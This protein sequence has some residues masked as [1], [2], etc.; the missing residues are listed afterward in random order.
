MSLHSLNPLL[1]LAGVLLASVAAARGEGV[2]PPLKAVP[3]QHV[4]IDDPFWS[5]KLAVWRGVTISDCLDKFDH[6]GAMANFDH[7]ARGE[8]NAAH[9]GPSFY[10]GLSYELIRAAADFLAERPDA[11]MEARVDGEIARIAAAAARDPDGYINTYTEM[12]EPTHRWGQNGGNDWLQHDV[13]N[14]GCLVDAAVHYYRAT[15]KTALLAVAVRLA[16]S[17]CHLMGP[18][19]RQNII[20]G[21]AMAEEAMVGLYQLFKEQPVLRKNLS[22]PVDEDQYLELARFWIDMRGHHEGRVDFGAFAQDAIPVLQETAIEGHAVRAT[23]MC[24]GMSAIGMASGRAE[25]ANAASRLWASMVGRRMYLTGGVGSFADHEEFGPDYV[26]P[27]NGYAETCAAVGNGFFDYNMNLAT[28]DAAAADELE[29]TLY[30]GSLAG[31]SLAG[32]TYFY[33]NPLEAG[34]NRLRWPW[35]F[36]PCCPPMFLKLMAAL[37]GYVYAT[38]DAGGV[39]LNLFI[40]SRATM[41]M[42]RT[43]LTLSQ[44]T[45]YPWA[46]DVRLNVDPARPTTFDLHIRIPAWSRGGPSAGGLYTSTPV[47]AAGA[48]TLLIN[49]QPAADVKVVRGYAQLHREWRGGDVVTLH[50]DM[51]VERVTA[52]PHV[53]ADRGRTALMRGPIVYCLESIDNAGR[54]RDLFLPD[55]ASV[56]T[57]DRREMLGGVVVLHADGRR[58]GKAGALTF[59]LQ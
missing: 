23:L 41:N 17:M 26:L 15:G 5:P 45:Q 19:P 29:R 44:T 54:V 36:C 46:G 6:E 7:V 10:D 11:A 31:V 40:G 56:S 32:N 14:A 48:F 43:P 30:N 57:E 1:G 13:Y 9:G 38:D 39:Y 55:S 20:P 16:N 4:S 25:Y 42:A 51:P 53:E 12:K 28:G 37:P 21:H 49:G 22:L 59:R 2:A 58:L 8:L 33:E 35:H 3:I 47:G 24:S 50:L 18:P 34:R 27:N 52:D